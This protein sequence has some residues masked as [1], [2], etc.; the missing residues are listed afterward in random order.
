MFKNSRQ[1][2]AGGDQI[3]DGHAAVTRGFSGCVVVPVREE[4]TD[5]EKGKGD[6]GGQA[7]QGE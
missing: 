3:H 6:E 7:A 2:S 1:Q 5:G 4:Q